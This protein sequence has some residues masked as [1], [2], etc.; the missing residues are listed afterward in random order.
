MPATTH[1][2]RTSICSRGHAPS[3]GIVP[4]FSRSRIRNDGVTFMGA[5]SASVE[6]IS[7]NSMIRFRNL[8]VAVCA[9]SV[10]SAVGR[11]GASA[12]F[13]RHGYPSRSAA[14]RSKGS[15]SKKSPAPRNLTLSGT[16]TGELPPEPRS[17]SASNRPAPADV[18]ER[19]VEGQRRARLNNGQLER[20]Y[21]DRLPAG[22]HLLQRADDRALADENG[23]LDRAPREPH[24]EPVR[25]RRQ[26][27]T[28]ERQTELNGIEAGADTCQLIHGGLSGNFSYTITGGPS[29]I[30]TPPAARSRST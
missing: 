28:A 7:C 14:R 20:H 27:R 17:G 26:N 12:S 29:I 23:R 16:L 5:A 30:G 11:A 19:H 1:R 9:C 18:R 22:C 15:P 8:V 2:S 21:L 24:R 25:R 4:A 6:P 10:L 3:L 13:R